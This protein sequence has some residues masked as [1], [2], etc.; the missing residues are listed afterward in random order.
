VVL[1]KEML[2]ETL[3]SGEAIFLVNSAFIVFTHLELPACGCGQART[4]SYQ[5]LSVLEGTNY[6]HVSGRG[7]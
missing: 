3:L 7:V 2:P 1:D 5:M 4:F 6:Y